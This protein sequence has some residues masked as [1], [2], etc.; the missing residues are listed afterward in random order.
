MGTMLAG[1]PSA[2]C[3]SGWLK[4]LTQP[5]PRPSA[6]AA[7]HRFCTAHTLLYKSIVLMCVRPTTTGPVRSRSQVM[8]R[9]IGD[10]TMPSSFSLL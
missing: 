1:M 10:S 3:S 5:T 7:S 6:R 2:F 4:M 8:H 9:L